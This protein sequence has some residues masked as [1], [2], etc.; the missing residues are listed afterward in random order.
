MSRDQEVR[1]DLLPV[2]S[3][4]IKFWTGFVP[5]WKVTLGEHD[6]MRALLAREL[7]SRYKGAKLG[8]LWSI[9]RPLVMLMVY[10]VAIGVFLGA[11]ASIP[12]FAVYVYSGL[13]AWGLFS[14]IVIGS[15]NSIVASSELIRKAAFPRELL[16]G[17]VVITALIDFAIQGVLLLVGYVIIGE[18]PGFAGLI[19]IIPALTILVLFATAAGLVLAAA[20]A[21]LRD[22]SFLTEVALQVGFWLVP[23]VYSVGI[24]AETLKSM[25]ILLQAYLANP[26]TIAIFGFRN[27]LW[28][29]ADQSAGA[30]LMYPG[31]LPG[32]MVVSTLIGV[33]AL[34]FAQRYFAVRG[35]D[36]AQDL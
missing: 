1:A 33:V 23:V 32:A 19:W 24:V 22:I 10:A 28:P 31:N 6:M 34:F 27:A 21:R 15:I 29:F 11:N 26:V 5:E 20:N 8:W 13:L 36:M 7:R 17:A 4:P 30:P 16:I 18:F 14:Q 9:A 12:G 3:R 2:V 35:A 25:P